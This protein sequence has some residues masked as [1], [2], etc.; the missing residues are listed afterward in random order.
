MKR[1][2]IACVLSLELALYAFQPVFANDLE[3]AM[4][5]PSLAEAAM[6]WSRRR[7]VRRKM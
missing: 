4:P 5:I 6:V 7:S 2:F 3:A 1:I